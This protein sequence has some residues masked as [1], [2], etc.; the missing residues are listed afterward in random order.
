MTREKLFP[1]VCEGRVTLLNQKGV[2]VESVVPVEPHILKIA[3]TVMAENI[4]VVFVSSEDNLPPDINIE[5][6][7]LCPNCGER[8]WALE[9]QCRRLIACIGFQ[10]ACGEV[11]IRFPWTRTRPRQPQSIYQKSR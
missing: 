3:N 6:D 1:F 8:H 9:R 7:W 5:F 10:L 2:Q 4:S 11:R